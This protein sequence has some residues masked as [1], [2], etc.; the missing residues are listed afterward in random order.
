MVFAGFLNSS[1]AVFDLRSGLVVFL[2]ALPLCLG[3]A[4]ASD[5]PLFAGIIAGVVGG[6]IT[7]LVSGSKFGVSGPAAGL[8]VI[9]AQAIADLGDYKMFLMAVVLAGVFQLILAALKAGIIGYYFPSSVIKGMLAAI[10]L[11]L[12]LKQIPHAM[13]LD[14]VVM[15]D[16]AFIQSDGQNTFTD[17]YYAFIYHQPGAVAISIISLALLLLFERPMVKK[18]KLLSYVPGAL[19]VVMVSILV[20][21]LFKAFIPEW[22]LNEEHLVVLPEAE[23]ISDFLSFFTFPEWSAILNMDVIVVAGTIAAVASIETLLCVE[24]T[25]KLDPDKNVTNTNRELLAQGTGNIISG[26]IGGLPVTQVIVRS[27]ANIDAGAKSKM[28]AV[29]HGIL[30]LVCVVFI[31]GIL[32]KIPL[33]SLAVVLLM[34]GYKLSKVALYRSMFSLGYSQFLPFLVTIIAI[35]L[36]DLLRGIGIGMAVSVF[37]ILRNNFRVSHF[38]PTEK[39]VGDTIRI[40]LSEEVTF[41]NKVS[42]Q[43]M[44]DNLPPHSVVEIDGSRSMNIDYDVLEILYNFKNHGAQVKDVQ[45]H[46][47]GIPE[48]Q[49]ISHH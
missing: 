33:S 36:T 46:F 37:F 35:L 13:G 18:V 1:K 31:P 45:I 17:I 7:G 41:L 34:V 3:I 26:L 10:G 23:G 15:G 5:A 19:V 38:Q 29:Y 4:L 48:I 20:N 21:G 8:T 43:L 49:V 42:I 40:E 12:I 28:S 6:I 11:L 2:V 9:V 22:E 47:I 24:A 27:S 39:K 30:L 14:R 16:Q 25:D 44:L 32:N